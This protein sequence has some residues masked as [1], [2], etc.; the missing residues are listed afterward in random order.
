MNS[1]IKENTKAQ[2][3]SSQLGLE[4]QSLSPKGMRPT[5]LLGAAS[6][7]GQ[8]SRSRLFP[9]ATG[10]QLASTNTLDSFLMRKGPKAMC[11]TSTVPDSE[12]FYDTIYVR[13][14]IYQTGFNISIGTLRY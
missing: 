10:V 4:V 7:R 9:Q 11:S 14:V 12:G 8:R 13:Q 3:E 1:S 2:L 6:A 5:A